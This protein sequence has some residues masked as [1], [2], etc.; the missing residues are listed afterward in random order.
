MQEGSVFSDFLKLL[1]RSTDLLH[2]DPLRE[3]IFSV[4]RLETYAVYLAKDLRSHSKQNRDQSLVKQLKRNAHELSAI[5]VKLAAAAHAKKTISPAAEWLVDNFY[6][7]EDQIRQIKLDLPPH[8]YR[9]LPKL[10][11]GELKNLPRV[12]AIALAF[13]AHTDS[14]IDSDTLRRFLLA[15]QTEMPLSIGELWAVAI[16][17]RVALVDHLLPLAQRIQNA[18]VMREEADKVSDRILAL[19]TTPGPDGSPDAIVHLLAGILNRPE[20]FDRAYIVQLLQ[21]LRDQD[22]K[23]LPAIDWLTAQ[24]AL[25]GTNPNA[26][27]QLDHNRLAAAQVTVGNIISSMRLLSQMDWRQFVESVSLVDSIF[28]SDPDGT[29]PK[30]DFLTRDRYRHVVERIARRSQASE[31]EVA[32]HAMSLAEA[33]AQQISVS[34]STQKSNLSSTSLPAHIGFYLVGEGRPAFERELKYKPK[35]S[36]VAARSLKAYPTV[37]YLCALGGLSAAFLAPIAMML[38]QSDVVIPWVVCFLILALIPVSELA[39]SIINHVIM[40]LIPPKPLPR[41]DTEH[42]IPDS[43]KTFVVIPTLLTHSA[44]ITELLETLHVHY[45]ANKN[46]NFYFALLTDFTDADSEV[47]PQDAGLLSEAERGIAALNS[48]YPNRDGGSFYLFH[49]KR[50]WNGPEGKWMGLERKRG[51]LHE[52]N[53]LLRGATDTSYMTSYTSHVE[54]GLA[55]GNPTLPSNVQNVIT[56]DSDTILPRDEAK[57]LVGTILHPLNQPYYDAVLE[58]VTRG[59]AILQPRVSVSMLSAS[60]TFFSMIFSG[61]TGLD[62]YTTAVSEVYQDLLDEGSYTG[63]GLYVIDAFEQALAGRIP[64]NTLL[65]HDLFE[66]CY[67]RSALVT[68]IECFDDFPSDYSVYIKRQHRWIRGDWQIALWLLPW[69]PNEEKKLVRNKLPIMSRWKIFDNL[70]RSLTPPAALLWLILAWTVLPGNVL[71]W[72][73]LIGLV[74]LFP[75]SSNFSGIVA[76]LSAGRSWLLL[77]NRCIHELALQLAQ[78]MITLVFLPDQAWNQ[79]DAIFRSIYR[80]VVSKTKR[81]EWMTF[82]QAQLNSKDSKSFK[83]FLTPGPLFSIIITIVIFQIRPTAVPVA[84]V[85]LFSWFISPVVRFYLKNPP[86]KHTATLTP[87]QALQYRRYAR[88]TWFFFEQFMTKTDNWLPPDNFQEEPTPVVAHRTSPTNIGLALIATVTAYDFGYI[89]LSDLISRLSNTLDS[90]EA[91]PKLNG[92]LFNWYDTLT[93]QPLHPRYISTVDSGNLAAHLLAVIQSCEEFSQNPRLTLNWRQGLRDTINILN[94]SVGRYKAKQASPT[95]EKGQVIAELQDLVSSALSCTFINHEGA[96]KDSEASLILEISKMRHAFD[97]IAPIIN[98]I[99]KKIALLTPLEANAPTNVVEIFLALKTQVASYQLDLAMF[100]SEN[101][102]FQSKLRSIATRCESLFAAMNFSFL[103]D[104]KRKVF[105]IG[106]NVEDSRLDNS[107]YDLL[108]SEARLTCLVAIAKGD[109]P[110]ES[111]FR[112]GR[113][114]TA[115]RAGRALISWTGTMFEYLMPLLVTKR[116]ANTILDETYLAVVDRQIEYGEELNVPWGVS[117]AGYYARDL[118]LNYQYGPFGVPG[119]GLKRG[120]SADLVV[121]PY[122]TMLASMVAPV[123]AL[124]NLQRLESLGAFSQY[125]FYESIDYT[126][127][128]LQKKQKYFILR[129]HMAHHQGMSFVALS[130]LLNQDIIQKR[131]HTSPRIQATELVLQEKV[132]T[133]A[134]LAKPRS[135]E[136]AARKSSTIAITPN[137][138]TYKEIDLP[139]PRLQILGNGQYMVMVTTSGAGFSRCNQLAITRWREDVTRDHWGSFVYIRNRTT[140][141]VWSAGHAPL[142]AKPDTYQVTYS[143]DRVEIR[144]TDADTITQTE[145]VVA[146]EDNVELRR[147]SITNQSKIPYEYEVTSYMEAVFTRLG[148][149]DAHPAF[150]N[151]FVQTEYIS[152][153][154]ALLA[155]RRRRSSD[156]EQIFGFHVA[157]V[158][159]NHLGSTQYETDRLR[160]LGRGH[161]PANPNVICEDRPL[162]N[163]VGAVLDPILSLRQRVRVMPGE[164]AHVTFATGVTQSRDEAIRLSDKYHDTHIFA[165]EA[166]LAWT[167]A[168]VQLRH[169]NTDTDKAHVF[170]R[171]AARIL[172]ADPSLRPRSGEIERNRRTQSSL[173]A[174]GISGDIP[175]VLTSISEEKDL[176]MV[177]DLLHA[178]EYLRLKGIRFDLVILN[179]RPP[180][181]LQQLQD[182]LQRQMQASGEFALLDKPGGIFIR[183]TDIMPIEDVILLKSRA[184]IYLIADKGSIEEQLTRRPLILGSEATE[185]TVEQSLNTKELS[186]PAIATPISFL[187][188]ARKLVYYNGIGGFTEDGREYTIL[189]SEKQWTPAPWINVIANDV[190]FGF[191]VSESGSGFTWA[192]NSRE[193]RLTPWS[194]DAVSDPTGEVV[195]LRDEETGEYWTPT[196]L[197]IRGRE[198]YLV[199]H[200]Q[201]YSQ[202]EYRTRGI[203]LVM[204]TFAP[205]HE[206]VK[207]TQLKLTNNSAKPRR[208]SMTSYVEW[209]LGVQRSVSS[210]TIVC[211][212][213]VG[214]Q[215]DKK[216]DASGILFATNHYNNEFAGSVAFTD[217]SGIAGRSFTCDRKGFIGRNGSLSAPQALRFKDLDKTSGSAL[218]PCGALRCTI[219]LAAGEDVTITLTLGSCPNVETARALALKY[220]DPLAAAAA[221]QDVKDGWERTLGTVI[222]TTPDAAMNISMNRWL[223]YQTISCRLWARSAFY[224]SGGAFGFRDQLQD[225]MA[226][227]IA[228]PDLTRQ[229]ILIAAARQ[230][231][232]GDVQHWWHP[233]TGRGVRTSFSDDLLW[234]PYVVTH[235]INT[236]GDHTILNEK[237]PFIDAPHL[238]HGEESSYTLPTVSESTATVLAHCLLTIDRSLKVGKHNLPLM[239]CGDWNDGMNRVGIHGSGESVW[240]GW[241]LYKTIK[242]FLPI[243][244][245]V[246]S[247]TNEPDRFR[248]YETHLKTLTDALDSNGWDGDWYRRAYF[249]NGEPLGSANNSECRIDSIAQSWS[250]LSGAAPLGRAR[251]AMAA[252][253]EYLIDQSDGLIKLFA[254]PFDKGANDPGYI[255]G[256]LP[257]VRENGGQYTH[258]AIWTVMAIAKLGNGNRAAELYSLLNPINHAATVA[259]LHK[260]KVEPYV[261]AA[262]IY[263]MSPHVG[264]GGWTWYTGSASWMYRAGLESILGFQIVD[265]NKLRLTPCI[266]THWDGFQIKYR[267]GTTNYLVEVKNPFGVAIASRPSIKVDGNLLTSNHQ[268]NDEQKMFEIELHDD[269]RDHVIIFEM[270]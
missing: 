229:Q 129:S 42:G 197:P 238:G 179:E 150:S 20:K 208:L 121:S 24:L 31:R 131:F 145:I 77:L 126:P 166:E 204:T 12:Y 256:Y 6:I 226:V 17:L 4:E 209:V 243:M 9:E 188:Q 259:G 185:M 212:Q 174:Y 187:E 240:M 155:E 63:K 254:P 69:V 230:F 251:Q 109:I 38:I 141:S 184:R 213:D 66:S 190:D 122:S 28:A 257:G 242:D 228:R 130:N 191:Q 255:K 134:P 61:I 172:Y 85:F 98:A 68:D 57:R 5:Y 195:Y 106:F 79:C 270:A 268:A 202:F 159:G 10:L 81:L 177:R 216:G 32:Q 39:L 261:I 157:V 234:L 1:R 171:L 91:M 105:S 235:Y 40:K 110:T 58:R 71:L 236:T 148:D 3:E 232:E 133:T 107:F 214:T 2:D 7:V 252:V 18:R 80:Q 244:D 237:V 192:I 182:E 135:D 149:D 86:P 93:L 47:M 14:R 82:S 118:Q 92:H 94:E 127:E 164:T 241:F 210:P 114:M 117:E 123:S 167:K 267:F 178:H 183:R 140:S 49:R 70:R 34:T 119:L 103:L 96:G 74:Y 173:W 136:V 111:W 52:F 154:N 50:L 15:F 181:Y 43:A 138:R 201:G 36:E 23:L 205:T 263:G 59:Y 62:P 125:G 147:V 35:L 163:T 169:L 248:A 19:V 142:N 260:Y 51:K 95:I 132:P 108:A 194:N 262:D 193:N 170:Q 175:I 143:E 222:V 8:Y 219:E 206:T 22:P 186:S 55:I 104:V 220:R 65:S 211:W 266:P 215:A 249:D 153:Q 269:Q 75:L 30:M 87:V 144:R 88:Y 156:E 102:D 90:T 60:R 89:G 33:A 54:S 217:I 221:L 73:A 100:S 199:R 207:V 113:Q 264:R 44:M 25:L 203:S 120:L 245:L 223:L 78:L 189:L 246:L 46:A 158:D 198:P 21:R 128:R 76:S 124:H 37:L 231:P 11:E 176:L 97:E 165:R 227:T 84:A 112:L 218:D 41:M 224:Q 67:A 83:N 265:G 27:I 115:V 152:A 13:I 48:Q 56:L 64:P 139:T 99:E 200:G 253:D 180:S 233:P 26:L 168:R 16:S 29:Y 239:G 72:T 137:L 146:P 225:A 151:L 250:V 116:F 247:R 162:S 196:P 45:L 53:R 258:A 161:T 101:P 160:F